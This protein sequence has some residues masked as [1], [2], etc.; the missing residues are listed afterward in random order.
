MPELIE[1]NVKAKRKPWI[2][3]AAH[4]VAA[5]AGAIQ[6]QQGK[7]YVTRTGVVTGEMVSD[8]GLF[9]AKCD[10]QGHGVGTWFWR[11][12]GQF[13]GFEFE[14]DYKHHIVGE[15]VEPGAQMEQVKPVGYLPLQVGKK[16][17]CQNGKTV[18]IKKQDVSNVECVMAQA[19]DGPILKYEIAT[20][21]RWLNRETAVFPWHIVSEMPNY[22]PEQLITAQEA[23]ALFKDKQ[24]EYMP[25]DGK[26][27]LFPKNYFRK[28]SEFMKTWQWR[29]K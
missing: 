15:Y 25:G 3:V 16:Y 12:D 14:P 4:Q 7:R 18:I 8:Q 11:P 13:N 21:R 5:P 20:G 17:L 10:L 26:W 24:L 27:Y 2:P 6:L 29:I 28:P 19:V 22:V 23:D 9:Y 1:F